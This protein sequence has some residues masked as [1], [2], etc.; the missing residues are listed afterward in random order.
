MIDL[1]LQCDASCL[2]APERFSLL[3]S[4]NQFFSVIFVSLFLESECSDFKF[5]A[6]VFL[7]MLTET[8]FSTF[9]LAGL[10]WSFGSMELDA[11]A[12]ILSSAIAKPSLGL[13][14]I[15]ISRLDVMEIW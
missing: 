7:L 11:N 10:A 2:R 15:S 6:S 8:S 5:S 12:N 1:K 3:T 14:A 9:N 13:G 4:I